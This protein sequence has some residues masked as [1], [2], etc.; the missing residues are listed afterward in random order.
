M[1]CNPD[2]EFI[3]TKQCR[4][5]YNKAGSDDKRLLDITGTHDLFPVATALTM[6]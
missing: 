2:D 4:D 1:F 3:P 6:E 5:L